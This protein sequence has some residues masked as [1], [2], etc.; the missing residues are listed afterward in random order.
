MHQLICFPTFK[1]ALL[2]RAEKR[3]RR[4]RKHSCDDVHH[5]KTHAKRFASAKADGHPDIAPS[6][7]VCR[8]AVGRPCAL[9]RK[10]GSLHS[11]DGM[12]SHCFDRRENPNGIWTRGG[13]GTSA[14]HLLRCGQ[15]RR[16]VDVRVDHP[17]GVRPVDVQRLRSRRLGV[18]RTPV[19]VAH[20]S[21]DP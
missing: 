19:H 6:W 17:P 3:V 4:V 7:L 11:Q 13:R 15:I 16:G 5:T 20:L 18:V 10:R 12:R 21:V 1:N 14:R 9:C 2:L 8:P